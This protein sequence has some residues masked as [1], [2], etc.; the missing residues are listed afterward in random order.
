MGPPVFWA[1]GLCRNIHGPRMITSVLPA[2]PL[3]QRPWPKDDNVRATSTS[4]VAGSMAP[5]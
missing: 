4:T 3:S 2:H 5:G 1:P